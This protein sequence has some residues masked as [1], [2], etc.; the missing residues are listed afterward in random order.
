MKITGV[1]S[2]VVNPGEG[3]NL[4]FIKIETDEGVHGWGEAYTQADRDRSIEVH[5]KELARYV[6]GRSPFNIKHF[7]YMAYTDFAGKR[8]AMDFYCAVSGMEQAMWD[9]VGKKLGAP[10]HNLLGGAC[11]DRIRVYANGWSR[12]ARTPS[13]YAEQATAVVKRGFTALKFDP[14]PAPWR[15]FIRKEDEQAAVENVRAVREAV[16]PN[17]DIL[18]EVH[19]RLAPM[20]AI[21]VARMM[22]EF[23]P[24]WYEEPVAA[25]N[26]DALAEVRR[27]ISIPV[28]TGEA[29]YTKS[30]FRQVF[31]KRA[32]DIINPDICN[33]GGILELK[34][35]AA[36]AEPH[37]VVVSPHNFNSTAIG[38]AASL[39][40]SAAI[41]NFLILEYFV[42][43][44]PFTRDVSVAPFQVEN[45]YIRVPTAP[46]LGVE[47]KEEAL[48]RYPARQT[49]RAIRQY[50]EEG[51]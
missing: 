13:E 35:I 33:T 41:P 50:S 17:V 19:R 26:V 11:R 30:D 7:T 29:L 10:V 48:A 49:L 27:N 21:R 4:L 5:V 16:G 51:P 6:E 39:Q 37:Y 12:R 43:F 9:I 25:E 23:K 28:V 3:K 46:G 32:A 14:F 1:K 36:M 44:E 22:E 8:G 24:F 38:L 42:N 34:E 31:E 40:L 47:L 20:H 45:G 18:V 15:M 2:Y